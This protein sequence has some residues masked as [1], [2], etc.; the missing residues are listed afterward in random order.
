MRVLCIISNLTFSVGIVGMRLC[1]RGGYATRM[2]WA[3]MHCTNARLCWGILTPYTQVTHM[4][5]TRTV[6][7]PKLVVR[8][9]ISVCVC[10]ECGTLEVCCV[11]GVVALRFCVW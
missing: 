6:H 1:L 10:G 2:A 8:P 11:P 5:R 3:I 9:N 4:A 7:P